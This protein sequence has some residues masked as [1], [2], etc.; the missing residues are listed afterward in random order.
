VGFADKQILQIP[1]LVVLK[2]VL[3]QFMSRTHVE[4]QPRRENR[5]E[6][7]RRVLRAVLY[8]VEWVLGQNPLVKIVF[9]DRLH[10]LCVYS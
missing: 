2:N 6:P 9:R 5:E 3:S 10:L 1:D 8:H 7:F 4:N